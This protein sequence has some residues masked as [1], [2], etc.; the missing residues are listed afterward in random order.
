MV[1]LNYLDQQNYQTCVKLSLFHFRFAA[2]DIVFP[3]SDW[4]Q[5]SDGMKLYCTQS[6][7]LLNAV[8]PLFNYLIFFFFKGPF[9]TFHIQS[10]PNIEWTGVKFSSDGKMILLSTDGGFIHLIDAF[11]GTRLHTFTVSSQ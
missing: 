7:F 11:Q 8:S 6:L 3:F 9:S 4:P 1:I 2:Q 10:D 5:T